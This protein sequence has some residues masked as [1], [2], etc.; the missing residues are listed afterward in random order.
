[1]P[2]SLLEVDCTH[3]GAQ[4]AFTAAA[5]R[6]AAYAPVAAK[7]A[8]AGRLGF[9]DLGLHPAVAQEV[10][11]YA[12]KAET[13]SSLVVAGIGGSALSARVF[14][15]LRRRFVRSQDIHVLDTADPAAVRA[16]QTQLHPRGVRLIGISKSGD[17]LESMAVFGVLESWLRRELGS[18]A[19]R[20]A[21]AVVAG[22]EANPLRA[23]AAAC[24]YTTFAVPSG[25][26]GRFSALTPVGLLPAAFLDL[27]VGA[28]LAGAAAVRAACLSS[29]IAANPAFALAA[30]HHAAWEGG[31]NVAVF[32]PYG[33]RLRPLAAWWAQLV[34]ES[35]GKPTAVA[36]AGGERSAVGPAPLAASGPADQHSLLQRLLAGPDDTLAILLEAPAGSDDEDLIVPLEGRGLPARGRSL[37]DIMRATI[38]A[39]RHALVEAGRPVVTIRLARS[40]EACVGALLTTLGMMV[41]AWGALL[42]VDPF[43]Q[44]AV[45][46]GKAVSSLL[47]GAS[48]DPSLRAAIAA[49]RA[50]EAASTRV[51][52]AGGVA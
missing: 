36:T 5:G 19:A 12:V 4:S 34:G 7:S 44:P 31:R 49:R 27:D 40:D 45:Q 50:A 48:D 25:V 14:A 28:L 52:R 29:D 35:L 51:A 24:G 17:T 20:D 3:A 21:I 18:D 47:L 2:H 37:G 11:A 15:A 30:I 42:G 38:E 6:L 46:R 16:V 43:G 8:E 13:K 23:H 39:T 33:E 32:M 10:E 41:V 26:G 22:E 1:M 9:L